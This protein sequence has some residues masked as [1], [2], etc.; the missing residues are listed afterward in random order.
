MLTTPPAILAQE[1]TRPPAIVSFYAV[2][3]VSP[4][5]MQAEQGET[6]VRLGWQTL[7]VVDCC[8][9]LEMLE[10]NH[11]VS[12][13][14][15][16]PELFPTG[17]PLN[18]EVEVPLHHPKNFGPII[19]RLSILDYTGKI[20]DERYL[21]V[22]LAEETDKTPTILHFAV[23]TVATIASTTHFEAI[24]EWAVQNRQPF[25]NLEF[26]QILPNRIINVE[27]PRET[28]WINSKGVGVVRP[29]YPQNGTQVQL[30]IRLV[31]IRSGEVLAQFPQTINA[32][33]RPTA[34]L[35]RPVSGGGLPSPTT[36]PFPPA[37]MPTTTPL[38]PTYAQLVY[39]NISPTPPIN[40]TQPIQAE[41]HITNTSTVNLILLEYFTKTSNPY[42]APVATYRGAGESMDR[43]TF[44]LPAFYENGT[45]T[46]FRL[47]VL[48]TD[49][50]MYTFDSP[51]IALACYERWGSTPIVVEAWACPTT[52]PAITR[53]A[54]FQSFE[55]GIVIKNHDT[56]HVYVLY[57]Y[58]VAGRVGWQRFSQEPSAEALALLGNPTNELQEYV[59]QEQ[60]FLSASSASYNTM[61]MTTP[62]GRSLS[63]ILVTSFTDGPSWRWEE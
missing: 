44:T 15:K 47:E 18:G 8:V 61:Y 2:N 51:E 53:P 10:A 30:E 1:E 55:G 35:P 28:L 16:D 5:V 34:S 42:W 63:I 58:E 6:S 9:N 19:Y 7:N 52:Y 48:G 27:L 57:H 12:V 38:V 45:T 46:K 21:Q 33:T 17:L 4:S 25:T 23:P 50:Y 20:Y 60:I 59:L 32:P 43:F 54:S 26:V 62:D 22:E 39:F 14:L 41:W 11:W 13:Y 29:R 36:T 31:D 37:P 3:P 40:R 56:G 24:V 49:G